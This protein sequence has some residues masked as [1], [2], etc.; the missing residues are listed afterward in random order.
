[1]TL[2]T[3]DKAPLMDHLIELRSRLMKSVAAIMIGFLAC[4]GFSED[5]YKFLTLPLRGVLGPD[6]K[7]IFTAPQE[8][9]FTYLKLSFLAGTF[10]ALPVVFTQLWLF[11]APGLYAH[12][13]KAT[14]PF[15][16]ATP[17]LF[18]VGGALA[19][20]FVMPLA[21]KFFHSFETSDI[22][23]MP[24]VNE[25][26]SLVTKLVFAFGIAFELPVGLLLMIRAGIISTKTLA[27]KRKYNIVI[28]FVVA[29][30]L[31]PPDPFTQVM[32]AIPLLSMYEFSILAGRRIER[33]RALKEAEEAA[34]AAD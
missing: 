16:I 25:Y 20:E 18:F 29:A 19:Y 7:M 12:E 5:L 9:F 34:E 2:G 1:M 30:V 23:L 8:A 28:A 27:E 15:L 22:Q 21:F 24:K 32:L 3:D 33:K 10:L 4:Y 13:R 17:I 11:V 26:L 6:V 14:L 31:T